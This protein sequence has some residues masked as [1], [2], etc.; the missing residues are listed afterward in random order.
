MHQGHVSGPTD[1]ND[2]FTTSAARI[3]PDTGGDRR[4]DDPHL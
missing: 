1:L 2:L 4:V 3:P